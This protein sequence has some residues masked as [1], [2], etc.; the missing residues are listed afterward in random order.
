MHWRVAKPA[1]SAC[2]RVSLVG[3]GCGDPELL[4]IKAARLI[5]SAD[6]VVYD[7]LVALEIVA[8]AAPDSERVYVGKLPRH[9]SVP[10]SEIETIMLRHARQGK[11]VVRLKGGDPFMFGRGGEEMLMLREQG[12]EVDICPGIS[13]AFGCAAFAGIPL[14]R[15]GVADGC[16]FIT[17]RDQLGELPLAQGEGSLQKLTVVV[18]MGVS[19][20]ADVSAALIGRGLPVDWPAAIV[21]TGSV[22]GDQ[23]IVTTLGELPAMVQ[24]RK[25]QS[26]ALLIIGE[27][28]R[29]SGQMPV[30]QVSQMAGMLTD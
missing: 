26:P 9:H 11:H 29:D 13:A 4:T 3:A 7:R 5:S 2:G 6:V 18:Y 8:L 28:V 14:T 30:G 25:I 17:G 19:C 12:I 10:Q 22:A 1:G 24:H 23:C 27:T 20:V 16:L 21:Q 15:R